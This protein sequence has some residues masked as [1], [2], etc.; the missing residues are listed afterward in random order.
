[1]TIKVEQIKKLIDE[2]YGYEGE[3][4]E[5]EYDPVAFGRR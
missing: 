1:M 2:Y 4:R 3:C 5:G